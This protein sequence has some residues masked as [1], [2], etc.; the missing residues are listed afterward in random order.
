MKTRKAA[1]ENFVFSMMLGVEEAKERGEDFE[2]IRTQMKAEGE[3]SQ[4]QV[5]E[6]CM[7][8]ATSIESGMFARFECQIVRDLLLKLY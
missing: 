8:I 4:D 1:R 2:L 5:Y 7:K 3:V 6:F